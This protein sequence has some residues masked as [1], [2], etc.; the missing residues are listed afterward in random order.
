MNIHSNSKLH[1]F[2]SPCKISISTCSALRPYRSISQNSRNRTP[3]CITK[4]NWNK[5]MSL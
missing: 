2:V 3:K 5:E 4:C 1:K